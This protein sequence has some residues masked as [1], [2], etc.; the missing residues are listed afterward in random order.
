MRNINNLVSKGIKQITP[1][2][3]GKPLEELER[4]YGVLNAI[5]MAS[6]ENPL[7]PSPKAIEAIKNYLH[8][9]H[10]YPDANCFLLK[11]ML[12]KKL[13]IPPACIVPANGSNEIIE[14]SLKAFLRPDYEVIIPEPTFSLYAKFTQALDGIPVNVPLKDFGIDLE[15]VRKKI[16]PKTRII[17]INNPNNPTGTIIKKREFEAFLYAL[18]EDIVVIVDEAYGEFASDPD[19]PQGKQYLDGPRWIITLRT[20]S[21]AYGLAGL[22]IGYGLAPKELTHYLNKIRQPFNVNSLAQV[23]ACAALTD[24]EHYQ[25][26]LS[27]VSTGRSYL[28]RELDQLNVQ[29]IPTQANFLM[30]RVN[31]DCTQVY[32][33]MLKQGVIIR[34]LS[35]F[36]YHDYIRVS[37]GTPEE[38][39]R[40]ITTFQKIL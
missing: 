14:L 29:Y 39:E 24:D 16:G 21:K 3:P 38:N 18:P 12:S 13:G 36:G 9:L 19:F 17:F 10:R 32:E 37:V 40:F 26:T 20:F 30:V 11:E 25:K 6:N 28:Y 2:I 27:V 22:R 1:Y 31:Q 8:S 35:S 15:A 5:K 23:A 7:G 33:A 4:E 34:P